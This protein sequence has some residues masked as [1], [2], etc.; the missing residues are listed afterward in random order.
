MAEGLRLRGEAGNLQ[1][2]DDA[3]TY[4][5]VERGLIT[6]ATKQLDNTNPAG[7]YWLCQ[8]FMFATPIY[9]PEPPMVFVRIDNMI[10]IGGIQFIGTPGNW[11]GF[12]LATMIGINVTLYATGEYFVAT[13]VV[14]KSLDKIGIRVRNKATNEII[15]DSGYPLVRFLSHI[16]TVV[17]DNSQMDKWNNA[18]LGAF[19]WYWYSASMPIGSFLCMN[20]FQGWVAEGGIIPGTGTVGRSMMTL[21]F[22]PALE[23]GKIRM[24][25]YINDQMG[26][27]TFD[28]NPYYWMF[29]FA[30]PG[31]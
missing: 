19:V 22:D 31:V 18:G 17:P 2:S 24:S 16:S 23:P 27:P 8:L 26:L 10:C 29:L 13:S 25:L 3:P 6:G 11:T 28:A 4:M 14:S 20:P 7:T 5:I 21:A 30:M 15:F 1:V 12:T 9:T